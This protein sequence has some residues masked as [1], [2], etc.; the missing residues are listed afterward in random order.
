[1]LEFVD[2]TFILE[3]VFFPLLLI[4]VAWFKYFADGGKKTEEQKQIEKEQGNDIFTA[5]TIFIFVYIGL[6][7]FEAGF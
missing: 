2:L 4:G 1:M 3:F 5:I 7:Y 6:V